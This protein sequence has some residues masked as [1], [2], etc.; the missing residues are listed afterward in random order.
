MSRA[1]AAAVDGALRARGRPDGIVARGARRRAIVGHRRVRLIINELARI[2]RMT[3][4]M[5]AG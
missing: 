2:F 5:R 3:P 1:G 4:V